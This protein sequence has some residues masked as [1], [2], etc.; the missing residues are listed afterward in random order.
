MLTVLAGITALLTA[1]K[2]ATAQ[3]AGQRG[4]APGFDILAHQAE[5]ARDAKRLDDAFDL[6]KRAL[7]LKPTWEDGWWNAGSISYD[8]DEY[9]EC[10]ADFRSLAAL[11]P[12][13]A[14]TWTMEGLCEYQLRDYDAALRSL[15]QVQRMRFQENPELS[16]AARL[17]LALVLTKLG[18]FE[19]AIILLYRL[20]SGERQKTNEIIVAVGIAGLRKAWI[21]PEVP[22]SEQDKVFKLGDAMATFMAGGDTKS[23]FDKFESALRDYPKEPD[24]HYRFGAF[25]LEQDPDRGIEEIKK[26]LELEPG[27]IPA[28]VALA[29]TYLK[30]EDPETALPYAEKA[31]NLGPGNLSAHIALGQV[32]L[33]AGDSAGAAPELELVVKLAPESPAAHYSL[34]QAYAKLGR[35]A[36]AE[37]EREAFKRVRKE[38]DAERQ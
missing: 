27:Y 38:A 26:T 24:V 36:D 4:R 33:A 5:V 1:V 19:K 20:T 12:D 30:R 35:R 23:A 2:P 8:I 22:E 6:Y 9:K 10:A 11:K 16:H 15:T 34:A 14:P 7:K 31:V 29:R 25:L 3:S 13:L 37:R 18:Y 17:H 28:L 21:P 32:L